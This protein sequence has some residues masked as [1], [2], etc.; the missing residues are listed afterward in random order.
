MAKDGQNP[1]HMDANFYSNHDRD[2]GGLIKKDGQESETKNISPSPNQDMKTS[3]GGYRVSMDDILGKNE[4]EI[5]R[6][7]VALGLHNTSSG[8]KKD[9][10]NLFDRPKADSH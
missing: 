3:G 5:D 9:W 10:E 7:M 6:E 4:S 2:S 1:D 8:K